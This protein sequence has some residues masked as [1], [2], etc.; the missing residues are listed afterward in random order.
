VRR[1]MTSPGHLGR[2]AHATGSTRK[3][4]TAHTG[5]ATPALAVIRSA[6]PL[7]VSRGIG[8]DQRG[9]DPVEEPV[10]AR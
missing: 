8:E 4:W 10:G 2:T 3:G 5:V 1:N 9:I 7:P 6:L